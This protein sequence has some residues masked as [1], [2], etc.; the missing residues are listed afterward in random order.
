MYG[1]EYCSDPRRRDNACIVIFVPLTKRESI[2]E[3]D[4]IGDK[5]KRRTQEIS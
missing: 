4:V 1:E 3:K 5:R 2:G